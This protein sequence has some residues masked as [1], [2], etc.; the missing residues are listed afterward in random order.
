MNSSS[1]EPFV[2]KVQK[3]GFKNYEKNSSIHMDV[4]YLFAKFHGEIIFYANHKKGKI[5]YF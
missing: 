1:M 2:T 5:M 3:I 4:Y